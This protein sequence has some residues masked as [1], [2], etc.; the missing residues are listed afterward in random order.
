M[1]N[2]MMIRPF[3]YDE[4]GRKPTKRGR[5][6]NEKIIQILKNLEYSMAELEELQTK[7][8]LNPEITERLK[9]ELDR[10]CENVRKNRISVETFLRYYEILKAYML[11]DTKDYVQYAETLVD[12]VILPT[13]TCDEDQSIN[14][15][16][17]HL[18]DIIEHLKKE[19]E[20]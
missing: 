5:S 1:P 19:P 13:K 10:M 18:K 11:A 6:R 2:D 20:K 9:A 14:S 4:P 17:T 3:I 8:G 7:K 12:A 16:R 15:V